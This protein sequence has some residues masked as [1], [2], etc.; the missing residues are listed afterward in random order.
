[1]TEAFLN[2]NG[3]GHGRVADPRL[4]GGGCGSVV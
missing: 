4:Q 2:V 3:T 1:M